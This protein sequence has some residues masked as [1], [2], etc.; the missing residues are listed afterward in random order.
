LR[1]FRTRLPKR[2]ANHVCMDTPSILYNLAQ[3]TTA[4]PDQNTTVF[5]LFGPRLT[6]VSCD[7]LGRNSCHQHKPLTKNSPETISSTPL[8]NTFIFQ[9]SLNIQ[10]LEYSRNIPFPFSFYSYDYKI[11]NS[12]IQTKIPIILVS[13]F[14]FNYSL[15]NHVIP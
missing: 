4:H 9:I 3:D 1:F 15:S 10:I 6:V 14:L 7:T 8:K 12:S 11:Q 2:K 5:Q 13:K